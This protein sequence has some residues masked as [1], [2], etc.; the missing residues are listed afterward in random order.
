MIAE[1]AGPVEVGHESE[2]HQERREHADGRDAAEGDGDDPAAEEAQEEGDTAAEAVGE[3]AADEDGDQRAPAVGEQQAAT[4]ASSSWNSR[5]RTR[6][7][8]GMMNV[9]SLLTNVPATSRRTGAG[10]VRRTATGWRT[11]HCEG[12]DQSPRAG[13]GACH[14]EDDAPR[15]ARLGL[16]VLAV[17]L[18]GMRHR[19]QL[20]RSRPGRA[21]PGSSPGRPPARPSASCPSTSSTGATSRARPRSC[22]GDV[23][24]KD[25][26][27]IAL[28]EMDETGVECL[29]RTPRPQLRVLPGG[30]A[31]RRPSQLR[32]R[33]PQPL[34]HRG[35]REDRPAPPRPLPQDAAH[36]GGGDRPHPGRP[37]RARLQR[38]FRDAGRS[39][40]PAPSATRRGRSWTTPQ[41]IP[42]RAGG[43]RLQRARVHRGR[44]P[45]RRLPLA[46]PRR[47]AHDLAF[48]LGPRPH[49]RPAAA[50]AARA[51][52]PR[53][54]RS[55][56][57][58]TS[59]SGRS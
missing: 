53:R 43:R 52:A 45:A 34:A 50:P 29:A 21:S 36:R 14:D 58:T 27:V 32:Q 8:Y 31:S 5:R 57:A 55:R 38:A 56:S 2:Q 49:A 40:A 26:D 9:P 13:R 6:V 23:R 39:S 7:R 42:A 10:S 48:L 16:L 20:P 12:L 59:R 3:E 25:A 51:S 46:H 47:R 28:Q 41:G 44:L 4:S 17:A 18:A 11:W 30:R 15:P 33:D 24:L 54:T 1:A 22:R 35:R 37:A 19:A